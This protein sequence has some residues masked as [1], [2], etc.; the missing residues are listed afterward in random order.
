MTKGIELSE[1]PPGQGGC[2][3]DNSDKENCRGK[4]EGYNVLKAHAFVAI[5]CTSSCTVEKCKAC[6][7]KPNRKAYK[8]D[9]D[10]N[11]RTIE[12]TCTEDS[13]TSFP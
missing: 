7:D 9:V 10:P 12:P 2:P 13:I 1:Y 6:V 11:D 3:T 4:K 5:K 8:I